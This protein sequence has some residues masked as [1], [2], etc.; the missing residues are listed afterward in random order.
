VQRAHHRHRTTSDIGHTARLHG[1]RRRDGA[2][3]DHPRQRCP[4][5]PLLKA[6]REVAGHLA[7]RWPSTAKGAA[8]GL[9]IVERDHTMSARRIALVDGDFAL[10][11][12]AIAGETPNW[13]RG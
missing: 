12:T 7:D 3:K 5:E 11:N 8:V 2:P 4:L 10:V 9:I 6:F 1:Y 13:G